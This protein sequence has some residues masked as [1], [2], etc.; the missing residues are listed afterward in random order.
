MKQITSKCNKVFVNK[1]YGAQLHKWSPSCSD[2][3][4]DTNKA[5]INSNG[6]KPF[7]CSASAGSQGQDWTT[8]YVYN[9]NV[10][11]GQQERFAYVECDYVQ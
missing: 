7:Y 11:N 9:L 5:N 10:V 3:I 8:S 6:K 1:G 2:L 4:T